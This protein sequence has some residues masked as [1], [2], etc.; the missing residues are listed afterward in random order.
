MTKRS[1]DPLF[2]DY[3][4]KA[5]AKEIVRCLENVTSSFGTSFITARGEP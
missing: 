5:G 2:Y 4:R 3:I 1:G